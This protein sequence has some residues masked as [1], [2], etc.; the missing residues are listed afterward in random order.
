MLEPK[1]PLVAL[2]V[3]RDPV[4]EWSHIPIEHLDIARLHHIVQQPIDSA[5]GYAE[6]IETLEDMRGSAWYRTEMVR[7]WVR[8]ALTE[9]AEQ[10]GNL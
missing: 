3:V 10:L 1:P 2:T 6:S 8:R 7:V 9:V 5:E 4:G